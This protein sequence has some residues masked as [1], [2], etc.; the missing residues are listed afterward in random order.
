MFLTDSKPVYFAYIGYD[1]NRDYLAPLPKG[2][3]SEKL[4]IGALV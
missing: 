4:N 1:T 3:L 2:F